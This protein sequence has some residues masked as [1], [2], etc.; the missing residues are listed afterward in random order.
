MPVTGSGG[1]RAPQSPGAS[2]PRGVCT[3]QLEVCAS[4]SPSP[5]ST[6]KKVNNVV[7][8]SQGDRWLPG[9]PRGAHMARGINVES[10]CCTPETSILLYA[11]YT[12][13]KQ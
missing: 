6:G 4:H 7:I 1:R 5:G 13:R 3:S 10:L 2:A 8:A 12:W 9:I 11:D